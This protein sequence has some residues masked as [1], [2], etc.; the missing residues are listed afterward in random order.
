MERGALVLF[1][2]APLSG[3]K[4]SYYVSR[5]TRNELRDR[6]L[7]LEINYKLEF[8]FPLFMTKEE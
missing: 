7:F 4:S 3:K 5:S 1:S 2:V 6:S 8:G